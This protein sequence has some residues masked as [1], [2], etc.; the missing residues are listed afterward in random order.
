LLVLLVVEEEEEE[1]DEK[2]E[3]RTNACTPRLCEESRDRPVATATA[4]AAKALA[5]PPSPARGLLLLRRCLPSS[6]MAVVVGVVAV[7]QVEGE[8]LVGEC[9]CSSIILPLLLLQL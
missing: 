9:A 6:S 1:E 8:V 4:A 7:R 3:G 5:V 2:E